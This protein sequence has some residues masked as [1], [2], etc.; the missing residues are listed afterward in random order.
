MNKKIFCKTT[1]ALAIFS[2]FPSVEASVYMGTPSEVVGTN[3]QYDG[4]KIS[5]PL[6]SNTEFAIGNQETQTITIGGYNDP[7]AWSAYSIQLGEDNSAD[8]GYDKVHLTL[9]ASDKI[10]IQSK[11]I[12]GPLSATSHTTP[13]QLNI[14][15]TDVLTTKAIDVSGQS[16]LNAGTADNRLG[17]FEIGAENINDTGLSI[18]DSEANIYSESLKIQ[19]AATSNY[20]TAVSLGTNSETTINVSGSIEI[21]GKNNRNDGMFSGGVFETSG[22]DISANIHAGENITISSLNTTETDSIVREALYALYFNHGDGLTHE[23]P[24]EV[25]INAGQTLTIN[26]NVFLNGEGATALQGQDIYISGNMTGTYESSYNG[27]LTES[28]S[29]GAAIFVKG[30]GELVL[31]DNPSSADQ[32]YSTNNVTVTSSSDYGVVIGPYGGADSNSQGTLKVGINGNFS[33]DANKALIV[34]ERGSSAQMDLAGLSLQGTSVG[35]EVF[36]TAKLSATADSFINIEAENGIGIYGH[37]GLGWMDDQTA[38]NIDLSAK[39]NDSNALLNVKGSEV[40]VSNQGS[41]INLNADQVQLN[42]GQAIT[43][44]TESN[45]YKSQVAIGGKNV[46]ITSSDT[47]K[48]TIEVGYNGTLDI[49]VDSLQINNSNNS[50][51]ILSSSGHTTSSLFGEGQNSDIN[52]TAQS[53]LIIGNW[54]AK[55]EKAFLGTAGTGSINANLGAS[56]VKGTLTSE[57]YGH[58]SMTLTDGYFEGN[59]QTSTNGQTD[60]TLNASEN[61]STG[62]IWTVTDDSTLTTLT[63]NGGTL[64]FADNTTSLSRNTV[65][66]NLTTNVLNGNEGTLGFRIDLTND[67]TTL[68]N[69]QLEVTEKASGNHYATITFIGESI[70]VDKLYSENWLV[71][72]ADSDANGV[73]FKNHDG[74]NKF[75]GNG[76]ITTWSLLF[77][78][79]ENVDENTQWSET[80]NGK[81]YWHLVQTDAIAD[82]PGGDDDDSGKDTPPEAQQIQNLGSSVAQAVGWLSEKNDLRRR[83]GE[84]RYGSQAGAWAK[85]F[86]RQDRA[87]GFRYNGFKQESTG[88]HVG[89]DTFATKNEHSAWLVGATLRYAHSTQEG[90][91][92]A[93]GGDGKLK[94]Y[95]G[96]IYATWMHESGSYMDILAQIGYYDQE[97]NGVNNVGDGSFDANYHNWGYGTSIEVGHMFTLS[98]GADDRPWYNHWFLEP[99]LE[100]SYFYVKG[101]EFK[102]STGLHVDQGD[103]D[104]LTG[105]AGFVLG[106]KV[107]CGTP[108]D[109]DKRWYQVGLIA[110]VTHEFL[111]DQKI[112]FTG[113]EGKSAEVKGHGLG[114]TSFYYGVTA[115]WQVTNNVRIYGE[116]DR[117]EGS[118]YTK[119]FGFNIGFKYSF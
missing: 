22:T 25:T 76:M 18:S 65:Y 12:L 48:S 87:E 32:P 117:E 100:L 27:A 23:A 118:H 21:Q 71:S 8:A 67:S 14:Y 101:E 16:T 44:N 4:V 104:F 45:Y 82:N 79:D 56:T 68:S 9:T 86:T 103:A 51:L 84:V 31:G 38:Q 95:S 93:Y 64:N 30:K 35:L 37:G 110:G 41:L 10:E 28:A 62:A 80:G 6:N 20:G 63:L 105:R 97:I 107:N 26:G 85:V 19:S 43:V 99:Q 59:T 1:L 15:S 91:E 3:I 112:T 13:G 111:G 108:D 106:K 88:V 96:K 74:T 49:N 114:G 40:A 47:N 7:S 116:L 115:D 89:Y 72:Q 39:N 81:G 57:K 113:T 29:K 50:K 58:I 54:I 83:L 90:L 52:L 109:L 2:I 61:S 11:I 46:I 24:Y 94:E 55:G 73:T 60:I 70:P 98:N 33:I 77:T 36:D 53:G 119:D 78:Q 17:T 92:T 75:T 42:G 34:Q 66:R 69:D 102:T 5:K